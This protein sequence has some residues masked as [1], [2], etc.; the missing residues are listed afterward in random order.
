MCARRRRLNMVISN[1]QLRQTGGGQRIRELRQ[2]AALSLL[3]LSAK[4]D[5]EFGKQIDAGH[6]NKIE[7]GRIKLPLAETLETILIGLQATY[8]DR[9]DVL[10]AFGYSLPLELPTERE[11]KE[12]IR[13]A[14]FSLNNSTYPICLIDYGQR[15]WAWNR[16]VPRLIGLHPDDPVTKQYYGIT[17]PDLTFNQQL[18]THILVANPNEYLPVMLQYIK[19]ALHP[20]R[21]QTWYKELISSWFRLPGFRGLWNML[22]NDEMR[23]VVSI[24]INVPQHG[25]LHF[26]MSTSDI[27]LDPRFQ[28]L[29]FTPFGARTLRACAIWAEEE[30]ID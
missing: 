24:Q 5:V 25:V 3:D 8:R 13:L 20:Y 9:R 19:T 15:L 6:I 23:E 18:P 12:G 10:G 17:T 22:P 16:F 1:R 29:H 11:I 26:R 30:G 7:T 28:I 21:A 27:L 2:S 14:A 4:L